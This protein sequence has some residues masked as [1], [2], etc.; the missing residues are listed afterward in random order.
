M[1]VMT[2]YAENKIFTTEKINTLR[3]Y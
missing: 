2:L 1:T 3:S